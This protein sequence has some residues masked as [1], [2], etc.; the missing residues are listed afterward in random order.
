[1]WTGRSHPR[2]KCHLAEPCSDIDLAMYNERAKY[3]LPNGKYGRLEIKNNVVEIS[4]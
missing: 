2:L 1:M 3:A 4:A